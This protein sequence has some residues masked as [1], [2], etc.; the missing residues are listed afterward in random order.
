MPRSPREIG[1]QW[2]T[3]VLC[4]GTPGARVSSVA[5]AA[6]SVGT[7]TRQALEV[8][9]NDA[10]AD[11]GLPTRLFVKCTTALAQRLMLGL[12]GLIHGEPGFYN[13]VRPGL[14]IEAP[15][16]YF[17]AVDPRTWRSIVVIEDVAAA[18]RARFWGPSTPINRER[19]EDLLAN[20]ATWHGALWESPRLA[21]WRWLKTPAEQMRVIDALIGL[22]DRTG[23]G[24]ER[25]RA[26]LP[27][28]MVTRR[29]DLYAAM[30][31]SMALASRGSR[32]YLHV[33]LH[34]ANTY[35][36]GDGR[37]GIADWQ[38]GL[39][40]SWAYDFGY[41]LATALEPNDRRAWERDL[42]ELY[43]DRLAA[44]GGEAIPWE[45]AWL[46]Y[47]QAT[48]YPYFAWVYTL[49]R[50]RLQPKF[51]PDEVS[52]LMTERIATAIVDLDSFGAVDLRAV[53]R[54]SSDSAGVTRGVSRRPAGSRLGLACRHRT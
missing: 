28:A 7:T 17:G 5:T 21:A 39:Q 13:Y 27:H 22:A 25:A 48:F 49:G 40:G 51:Q 52:L 35:L 26:V 14:R 34:I 47:R 10:G 41:L 23:V 30:R 1:P 50:S 24:T 46:A 53:S 31:R 43:L 37:L 33:D 9:Y 19:I 42:L 20:A 32:T 12:G 16:G 2:L 54:L 38:I 11:A 44:A 36:T 3:A 18:R 4:A 15:G 29:A 8:G 45:R 6:G